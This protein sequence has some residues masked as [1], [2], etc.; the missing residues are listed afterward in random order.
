MLNKVDDNQSDITQII[1]K[2]LYKRSLYLALALKPLNFTSISITTSP[3]VYK[4]TTKSRILLKSSL[5][6]IITEV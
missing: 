2:E 1:L 4:K 5:F 6:I 3:K